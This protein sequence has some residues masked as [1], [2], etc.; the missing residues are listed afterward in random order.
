MATDIQWF[1]LDADGLR[2]VTKLT[3]IPEALLTFGY[4][5]ASPALYVAAALAGPELE[6]A[7]KCAYSG[8]HVEL[9]SGHAYV[10]AK[11]LHANYRGWAKTFEH[12]RTSMPRPFPLSSLGVVLF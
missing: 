1:Q 4:D 7:L 5:H 10:N 9:E 6:V 8:N 2:K 11:W 3:R 12:Y